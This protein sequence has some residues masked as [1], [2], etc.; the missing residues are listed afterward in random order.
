[1]ITLKELKQDEKE[2]IRKYQDYLDQQPHSK[3]IILVISKIRDQEKNH[4]KLLGSL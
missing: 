3:K 1:M 4:L 2:A